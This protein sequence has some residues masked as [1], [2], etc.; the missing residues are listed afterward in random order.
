MW[1]NIRPGGIQRY[2]FAC[3]DNRRAAHS[4]PHMLWQTWGSS[5]LLWKQ[6]QKVPFYYLGNSHFTPTLSYR[7][8]FKIDERQGTKDVCCNS[9]GNHGLPLLSITFVITSSFFWVPSC[10]MNEYKCTVIDVS[11]SIRDRASIWE[12]NTLDLPYV[13]KLCLSDAPSGLLANI[14]FTSTYH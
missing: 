11:R 10:L 4:E 5:C 1:K 14:P 9:V 3:S 13:S 7:L 8:L 2:I 12:W 6:S